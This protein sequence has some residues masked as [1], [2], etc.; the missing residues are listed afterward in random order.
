MANSNTP[1]GFR[2]I[3]NL[4]GTKAAPLVKCFIPATDGTAVFPGDAV[5]VAGSASSTQTDCQT[6]A[7]AAATNAILGVVE[8]VDQVDEIAIGSMNLNRLHR[9]ASTA[10][11]VYVRIDPNAMYE[12]Q[13]TTTLAATDVGSNADIVVGAGN[14]TLG[15]SGMQLDESTTD[16][17]ATLAL[18]ILGIVNRPDNAVGASAKAIVLINN[19][20]LKG[21]TGTAGV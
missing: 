8:S 4:A 16:T 1:T 20:Q 14:A 5:K 3:G 9:P 12:I 15:L 6:V 13:A 2:Y 11:F 21:G 10:M 18:K 7:Q 19:H 17:T